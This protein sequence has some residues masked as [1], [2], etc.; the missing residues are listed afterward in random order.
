MNLNNFTFLQVIIAACLA[1]NLS[2][3]EICKITGGH[4]PY[5]T[6]LLQKRGFNELI[7]SFRV[8]PL[9]PDN[10]EYKGLGTIYM[11]I[12]KFIYEQGERLIN[13]S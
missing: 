4:L 8:Q 11:D 1:R 12:G 6:K 2:R 7:T 5:I 3:P 13:E 10:K 9:D